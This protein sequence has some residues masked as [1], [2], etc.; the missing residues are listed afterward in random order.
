MDQKRTRW[1]LLLT[2]YIPHT[3]LQKTSSPFWAAK[4]MGSQSS[5]SGPVPSWI[6]CRECF[7]T[8][9][10]TVL[11]CR[12][13][14]GP[15]EVYGNEVKFLASLDTTEQDLSNRCEHQDYVRVLSEIGFEKVNRLGLWVISVTTKLPTKA[16]SGPTTILEHLTGPCVPNYLPSL[17]YLSSL[18]P[19]EMH[20][21]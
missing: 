8:C 7:K 11:T 4:K 5:H 10:E 17:A 21:C 13:C 18:K 15:F 20:N 9:E 3:Y 16:P 6:I 14:S 19:R 2:D 12:F 1:S